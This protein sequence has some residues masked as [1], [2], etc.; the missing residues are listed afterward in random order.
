MS[1][2]YDVNRRMRK[3]TCLDCKGVFE[4]PAPNAKRCSIC[5]PI[6]DRQMDINR[7]RKNRGTPPLDTTIDCASPSRDDVAFIAKRAKMLGISY[8]QAVA[9]GVR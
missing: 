3:V 8:G 4:S 6:H 7:C 2:F 1:K 9:M 5:A